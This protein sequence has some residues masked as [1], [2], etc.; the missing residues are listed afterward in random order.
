[1]S[2]GALAFFA[3]SLRVSCRSR[4]TYA[5][6]LL[7]AFVMLMSLVVTHM[8]GSLV[9]APGLNLFRTIV[10][11]NLVALVLMGI[12]SFATVITEEREEMTL[13]LLK[14][15][16]LSSVSILLGKSTS[17]LLEVLLIILVQVPFILL[18]VTLGGVSPYQIAACLCTCM[19][20]AVLLSGF[21]L[22]ASIC[23]RSSRT[24]T[25]ASGLL[26]L[27]FLMAPTAKGA[28]GLFDP[29]NRLVAVAKA[30]VELVEA[31]N[32]FAASAE[33]MQT[34]FSGPLIGVQVMS[35]VALGLLFFLLSWLVFERFTRE[36]GW[37]TAVGR[38]VARK[39]SGRSQLWV[40]RTWSRAIAWKDFHFVSG[41]KLVALIKAVLYGILIAVAVYLMPSYNLPLLGS[42]VLF[43]APFAGALHLAHLIQTSL[44]SEVNNRTFTSLMLLPHPV[45]AILYAKLQGNL[46]VLLPELFYFTMAL[47]VANVDE[48][49][50]GMMLPYMAVQVLMALHLVAFFSLV[51]KRGVLALTLLAWWLLQ[52]IPMLLFNIIFMLVSMTGLFGPTSYYGFMIAIPLA[53]TV[54]LHGLVVK[55]ARTIAAEL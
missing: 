18:A 30:G 27:L 21:G 3:R 51:V 50:L 55:R 6:R 15:S 34:G 25:G 5:L 10:Y 24:A 32:P 37:S 54:I 23:F 38:A 4:A 36:E 31:T 42:T 53:L 1:V 52:M 29:A 20:W 8:S 12:G 2:S 22:L 47:T 39:T 7:I 17:R 41:G 46:M 49:F 48:S 19:A 9:G 40:D 44:Q 14:M 11:I 45:W 35:N 16:A 33:I 26:L 28:L 13:G 43:L